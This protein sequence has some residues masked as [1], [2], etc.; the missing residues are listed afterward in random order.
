MKASARFMPRVVVAT[1]LTM[2]L[3]AAAG[4]FFS[5][6][7]DR[8]PS[9]RT[10]RAV[11]GELRIGTTRVGSVGLPEPEPPMKVGELLTLFIAG[12]GLAV[13]YQQWR[14]A[15]REASLEKYYERL[16]LSNRR[17]EAI[18]E[19]GRG[20][21]GGKHYHEGRLPIRG[22]QD[23]IRCGLPPAAMWV[24]TEID[25]LGYVLQKYELGYVD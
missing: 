8:G 6:W 16:D 10:S 12:I 18:W 14:S 2:T 19:A 24:Y 21:D 11:A 15:R 4:L 3:L 9:P 17:M 22:Q 1:I 13:G 25:N 7:P 23:I 5:I 20:S